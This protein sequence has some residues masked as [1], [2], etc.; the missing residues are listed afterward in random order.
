MTQLLVGKRKRLIRKMNE[1]PEALGVS[2]WGRVFHR[3]RD[4]FPIS[5][6]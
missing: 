5:N 2:K 6:W 4:R 3:R 1:K